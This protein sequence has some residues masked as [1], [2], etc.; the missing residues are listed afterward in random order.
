MRLCTTG[1]KRSKPRNQC[2]EKEKKKWNNRD[3]SPFLYT[4]ASDSHCFHGNLTSYLFLDIGISVTYR[5]SFPLH[6]FNISGRLWIGH[7]S[8]AC[9]SGWIK[10][11]LNYLHEGYYPHHKIVGRLP[12]GLHLVIWKVQTEPFTTG[13][14]FPLTMSKDYLVQLFFLLQ[15]S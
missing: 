6:M 10:D 3:A 2:T 15:L 11:Q 9:F 12:S 14:Y 8:C 5:F 1:E 4:S 7:F 13:I